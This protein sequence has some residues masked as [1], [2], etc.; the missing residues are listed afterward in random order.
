M[1][2][3]ENAKHL[4]HIPKR[5][6]SAE[7]I[8]LA[9]MISFQ[10]LVWGTGVPL[11]LLHGVLGD[12]R[13]WQPLFKYLPSGIR[14]IALRFPFFDNPESGP[15]TVHAAADYTQA[16]LEQF[17]HSRFVLGGNSLGGHVAQHI[18]LR[19][20]ERVTGLVLTGSSG[21][22]ERG[23]D[24]IPG[25]H[26]PREWVQAKTEEVFHD[27][28]HADTELVDSVM[29]VVQTRCYA[30]RLIKIAISAKRDY[31]GNQIK[32][33]T[34][35]TLLVWGK[36]DV[37]TRPEVAEEFHKLIPDSELH[38]IDKCGHTPMME[39]PE[40]FGRLLNNWWQRRIATT[41]SADYK[42]IRTA[43]PAMA[44]A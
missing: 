4:A 19:M 37:V 36:Q 31:I 43:E 7:G 30:R 15:D 21:L 8:G 1:P 42:I 32:N 29:Q 41:D 11:V 9:N 23:F 40:E 26:P 16:F 3:K 14:A 18:A 2:T 10:T 38:W 13:N 5:D 25:V 24:K 44:E 33:L 6:H 35:P 17:G 22:Y 34:C 39:Y 27:P 12:N 28:V 20:P